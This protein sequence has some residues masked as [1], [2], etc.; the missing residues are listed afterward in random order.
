M[1]ARQTRYLGIPARVMKPTLKHRPVIWGGILGTVYASNGVRT[2][3]FDYDYDAAKEF[4]GITE[5]S[6]L[7]VY[8]HKERIAYPGVK[9]LDRGRKALWILPAPA[10]K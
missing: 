9:G 7:R 6:D 8:P 3:Y 1:A 5:G 4:A 2:E 10:S